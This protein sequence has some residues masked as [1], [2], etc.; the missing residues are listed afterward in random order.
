MGGDE[1][2]KHWR[3]T[4]DFLKTVAN[5]HFWWTL[6]CNGQVLW[7]QGSIVYWDRE[8]MYDQDNK[9]PLSITNSRISF[10]GHAV[11]TRSSFSDSGLHERRRL[12]AAG[13]CKVGVNI[14]LPRFFRGSWDL[15]N[16]INLPKLPKER[17]CLK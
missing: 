9:T 12:W 15:K 10:Y 1:L 3:L 5:G 6:L 4:P 16:M 7:L 11:N 2:Q 8:T 17:I 14:P 13:T